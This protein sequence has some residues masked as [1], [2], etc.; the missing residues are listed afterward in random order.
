M[1]WIQD[2]RPLEGVG[3]KCIACNSALARFRV[4][5]QEEV[6]GGFATVA[7]NACQRCY[8]LGPDVLLR[9]FWGKGE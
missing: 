1:K 7:V 3:G 6:P 2:V 9:K 8:D 5:L 4:T